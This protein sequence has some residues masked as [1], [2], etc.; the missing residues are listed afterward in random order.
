[1]DTR[2]RISK[3]KCRK[4]SDRSSNCRTSSEIETNV[5][6]LNINAPQKHPSSDRVL[7]L[8]QKFKKKGG[9]P[10]PKRTIKR[11]YV[12]STYPCN[13]GYVTETIDKYGRSMRC[14]F[15]KT[16]E[17]AGKQHNMALHTL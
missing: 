11:N 1:M 14:V 13:G 16:N 17:E 5:N 3:G 12:V 15:S 10:M 8:Y 2:R 7:F 4:N 6:A 9:K